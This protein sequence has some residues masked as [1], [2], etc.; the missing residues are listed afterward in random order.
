MATTK[1]PCPAPA[2]AE[3]VLVWNSGPAPVVER[4]LPHALVPVRVRVEAANSL[5]NRFRPDPLIR[6]RAVLELD[7]DILMLWVAGGGLGGWI[8][9]C[10]PLHAQPW[11][12]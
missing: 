6:T 11:G 1:C 9:G 3:I 10:F 4:D 5:N 7:D 12:K 2:V 8:G